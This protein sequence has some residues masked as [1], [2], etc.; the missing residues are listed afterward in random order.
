MTPWRKPVVTVTTRS[1][2]ERQA[3]MSAT[4]QQSLIF[5]MGMGKSTGLKLTSDYATRHA[6]VE[7]P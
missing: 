7:G 3:S 5:F 2:R 6:R 1:C 4:R